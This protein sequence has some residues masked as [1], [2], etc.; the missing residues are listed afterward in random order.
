MVPIDMYWAEP[1][2]FRSKDK[3]LKM[4]IRINKLECPVS[5]RALSTHTHTRFAGRS[6]A[7]EQCDQVSSFAALDKTNTQINMTGN[8]C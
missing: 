3:T 2:H 8:L 6:T 5:V 7:V 4:A 1:L